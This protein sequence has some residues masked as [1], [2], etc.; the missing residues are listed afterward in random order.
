MF[1]NKKSLGQNFLTTDWPVKLMVSSAEIKKGEN[2][3]EIGPGTGVLTEELIETGARVF[4]IEKDD[5]LIPYLKEK[6][7]KKNLKIFHED[8]LNTDIHKIVKNLKYKVVANIPYYITGA[9]LQYFLENKNQPSCMFLLVQKEVAERIVAKDN[10]ESLLSVSVKIFGEPKII[11]IVSRNNFKPQP[12]VDSAILAIKNISDTKLKKEKITIQ[13]FFKIVKA[14][15]SH[16]RKVLKSNLKG[17]VENI[18]DELGRKRAEDLKIS[19]WVLLAG[20]S[21]F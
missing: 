9:I 4:A 14:G 17:I 3:I 6:F 20:N 21:N 2:I 13:N 8:I 7:E 12:N 1:L 5:R 19:D 10:K 15:F 11:K 18:P 16:K